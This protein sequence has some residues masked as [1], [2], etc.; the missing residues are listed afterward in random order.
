MKFRQSPALLHDVSLF[1]ALIPLI[2]IVNYYLTY[3]IITLTW[4]LPVTFLLDTLEGYAAWGIARLII[5]RLD[6][7]FPYDRHPLGRIAIQC[8]LT[9]LFGVGV[10][11]ALTEL[12]NFIAT[13]KPVPIHFYTHDIFLFL[14][15]FLVVNG[16]YVGLHYYGEYQQA[17][18]QQ[19]EQQEASRI[20]AAGITVQSGRQTVLVPFDSIVG[21]YIDSDYVM[22]STHPGPRYVVSQSLD[23]LEAS[24]PTDFFFRLNR[25]FILHRDQILGFD[26]LENGK[27]A[28]KLRALPSFPLEVVVSRT[29]AP[30]FKRWFQPSLV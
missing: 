10:I 6:Y 23:T 16:I 24:L 20:R 21:F 9:S 17:G 12:V 22:L 2:N 3:P 1:L 19:L 5:Q 15:W 29:K 27:V 8:T 7:T 18:Q 13:N 28:A 11:S 4:K 25:Q 14:I 26:R 30:T